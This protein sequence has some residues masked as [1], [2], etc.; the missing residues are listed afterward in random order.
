MKY[1]LLSTLL[2]SQSFILINIIRLLECT[3][4]GAHAQTCV[5]KMSILTS[6][7][8]AQHPNAG[9]NIQQTWL[10]HKCEC[11]ILSKGEGGVER[12]FLS[13]SI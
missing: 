2:H 10:P 1:F 13:T 4:A 5:V 7:W 11:I 12:P 8:G 3:E 6:I 9:R